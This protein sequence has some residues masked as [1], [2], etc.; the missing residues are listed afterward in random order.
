MRY[1]FSLACVKL[2]RI[3]ETRCECFEAAQEV[4]VLPDSVSFYPLALFVPAE[5]TQKMILIDAPFFDQ[6]IVE[7]LSIHVSQKLLLLSKKGLHR[8]GIHLLAPPQRL[9]QTL[10]LF[11]DALFEYFQS[12]LAELGVQLRKIGYGSDRCQ[13][14]VIPERMA[15]GSKRGNRCDAFGGAKCS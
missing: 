11:A 1:Q 15:F 3:K 8:F 14:S 5:L 6:L 2:V 13:N 12:I 9:P 4:I 10:E 7:H